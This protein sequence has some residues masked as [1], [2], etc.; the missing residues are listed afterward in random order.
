MGDYDRKPME[1]PSQWLRLK[2]KGDEVRFRIAGRPLRELKVWPAEQGGKPLE[3]IVTQEFTPGQWFNI[4]SNPDWS[5]SEVYHFVVIDKADNN[6]KIFTATGGVYGKIRDYAQNPE[7]GNPMGYDITVKRTEVPGKYYEVEPSPN[8]SDLMQSELAKAK[9]LDLNKM[10]PVARPASDP[11]PDDFAENISR[12]RLPWEPWTERQ[13]QAPAASPTTAPAPQ[14]GA[15][16]KEFDNLLNQ[17]N[18]S[19]DFADEPVN[20]DDIPF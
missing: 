2:S 18:G 7:W 12:E 20:L 14:P 17:N 1:P 11:Q 5:V 9:M 16:D 15:N 13:A 8:K 4:M 10:L 6:A 19:Q 3:T